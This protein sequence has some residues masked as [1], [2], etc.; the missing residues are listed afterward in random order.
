MKTRSFVVGALVALFA[1]VPLLACDDDHDHDHDGHRHDEGAL[2]ESCEAFHEICVRAMK[3][4]PGA[5][6]CDEF[7]H[8]EGRTETECAAKKDECLAICTG[9]DA[10]TGGD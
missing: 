2:P 7:T 4:Q 3:D 6:E 5:A 9:A 8:V 10:A 1:A